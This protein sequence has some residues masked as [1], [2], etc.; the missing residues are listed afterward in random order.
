MGKRADNSHMKLLVEY[1]QFV[2]RTAM[3]TPVHVIT[4]GVLMALRLAT[5]L[6][7]FTLTPERRA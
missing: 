6:G 7:W 1:I 4:T 3:Q 5:K 2:R